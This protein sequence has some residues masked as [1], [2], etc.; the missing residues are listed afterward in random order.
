MAQ[1]EKVKKNGRD[2]LPW[3]GYFLDP[4]MEPEM[5]ATLPG[6]R[7]REASYFREQ[8]KAGRIPTIAELREVVEGAALDR[9][10]VSL[11]GDLT[12]SALRRRAMKYNAPD[13]ETLDLLR[14]RVTREALL[15]HCSGNGEGRRLTND[16]PANGLFAF[17]WA[18]ALVRR[19]AIAALP[20]PFFWEL[21]DGIYELTGRITDTRRKEAWPVL[22]WLDTQVT[23]LLATVA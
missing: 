7:Q 4:K 12:L 8:A 2:F 20:L 14:A 17:I 1:K 6:W 19:K 13:S 18:L 15:S 9:L 21:E 23:A 3:A 11:P 10:I 16:K 22:G 5:F